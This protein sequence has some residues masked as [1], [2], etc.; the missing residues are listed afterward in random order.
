MRGRYPTQPVHLGN[1]AIA[2]TQAEW[3]DKS[4]PAV[5]RRAGY[6]TLALGKITHHPGGRTGKNWAE[7]PE[8]L[9]GVWD[10]SWIPDSPWK[11]P[12][13]M[14]HGYAHGRPR[15]RGVSPPTE[16]HDGPDTA[17]PDAWVSKEAVATLQSLADSK[18]PWFF[19]VGLFKPHLPFAAPQH[20][21]DRHSTEFIQE[22]LATKRPT[23]RIGW[24]GSG[25]F[26]G[27]YGHN[28]RDPE[29]DA[30]YAS[31]LRHAYAASVSYV[32][33]QIGRVL[34]SIDSL[35]L[36]DNTV[37]VVW[38]DHGFLLGEQAIWGKHCLYEPALRSP[39]IVRIPNLPKPGVPSDALVE[40]VDLFP[41]LLD[42]CGIPA[43]NDL[44]GQSLRAQLMDP[45]QPS[46]KPARGFWSNN[47]R[48]I[49]TQDWRY[50]RYG[51]GTEQLFDHRTDSSE[52]FNLASEKSHAANLEMFRAEI[53]KLLF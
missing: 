49:R 38:S 46:G 12:E 16:A 30:A 21:H 25:E 41:T 10:R 7:G 20:W 23:D 24:H 53:Q 6:H 29:T 36:K 34:E 22:P 9:P 14:M 5:F 48:T 2:S 17:Y 52:Q 19:A 39:L 31:H 50:I 51:D 18:Q 45:A 4:L 43:F 13:A 11:T 26:R 27:N 42:L 47:Q 15:E 3:V 1:A 37:I 28:G 44:D 32:D 35:G 33:A 8:E 40:T